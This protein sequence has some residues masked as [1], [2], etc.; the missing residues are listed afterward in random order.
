MTKEEVTYNR[1][2]KYS[3]W[4]REQGDMPAINIDYV[5][6]KGEKIVGLF[7]IAETSWPLEKI[8]MDTVKK[9][10]SYHLTVF[11]AFMKRAD[12][13]CFIVYHNP[14]LTQFKVFWL[15]DE[16]NER[17]MNKEEYTELLKVIRN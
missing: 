1:D 12:F 16:G 9:Y 5:E 10:K 6:M 14:E 7:E 15:N 8:T 13:Q 2:L 3:L 17:L 4:H 11:G